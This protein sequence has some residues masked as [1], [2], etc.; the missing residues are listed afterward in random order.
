MTSSRLFLAALA[1]VCVTAAPLSA[2]AGGQVPSI[3]LDGAG[4]DACGGIGVVTG[5]EPD[6][7][8]RDEPDEYAR[9]KDRLP[10]RTLVWLC[11]PVGDWQGIVYPTGEF[12][13]LGDCQV[14][15]PVP[16]P[17]PYAGPCAH[18]WVTARNLALVTG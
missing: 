18:G 12:Q 2:S 8:V 4:L 6:L 5:F 10:L 7:V 11:E 1:A 17:R 15:S 13:D 14:S 16:A 3:G 9:E